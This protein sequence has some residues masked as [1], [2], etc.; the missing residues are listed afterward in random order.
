MPWE[1]IAYVGSGL[2]LAAFIVAVAAWVYRTK[3]LE[4]ERTLRLAPDNE[5]AQL[6]ER[7]LEFFDV[8]TG[9]LT[10]EQKYN[11][12]VHQIRERAGRFRITAVVVVTIAC[13]AAG[14]SAFAILRVP[15]DNSPGGFISPTPNAT[16]SPQITPSSP[17]NLTSPT[18]P[19]PSPTPTSS[20]GLSPSP[21][22]TP[23][24]RVIELDPTGTTTIGPFAPREFR[25]LTITGRWT[26]G[27][28]QPFWGPEGSS[29]EMF[30]GFN[31]WSVVIQY[32]D[33]GS[34]VALTRQQYPGQP[35]NLLPNVRVLLYMN[36]EPQWRWDNT[37]DSSN[38]M[39]VVLK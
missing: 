31:K 15:K 38:P 18:A 24:E 29:G 39:R 23:S 12:A 6:I 9:G 35:I 28:Q 1:A 30:Q 21:S 17:I 26:S 20:P 22:P 10:R 14:V 27:L 16:P 2:T 19:P 3:I 34:G 36:D 4:R 11:L 32:E 33:P 25:T 13:L 8:D 7:T 37:N 5:R